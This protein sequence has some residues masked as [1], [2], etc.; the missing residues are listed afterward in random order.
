MVLLKEAA[1]LHP[2]MKAT[3]GSASKTNQRD[4]NIEVPSGKSAVSAWQ[5]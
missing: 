4:L 1:S 3:H 5:T 2:A